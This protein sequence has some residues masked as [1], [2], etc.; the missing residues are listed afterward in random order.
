MSRFTLFAASLLLSLPTSQAIA[1]DS[2]YDD[3]SLAAQLSEAVR[4]AR[5]AGTLG[6]SLPE[7]PSTSLE[8]ARSAQEAADRLTPMVD[9]AG[10]VLR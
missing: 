1:C 10:R 3:M 4:E 7:L 8:A 9:D 5:V 2:Y 6:K